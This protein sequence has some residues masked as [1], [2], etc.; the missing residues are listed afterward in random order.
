MQ[1]YAT[2]LRWCRNSYC[3]KVHCLSFSHTVRPKSQSV[4]DRTAMIVDMLESLTVISLNLSSRQRALW[5]KLIGLSE[6]FREHR[7]TRMWQNNSNR[8]SIVFFVQLVLPA[9]R[10]YSIINEMMV[11]SQICP[12]PVQCRLEQF[13][14]SIHHAVLP[15]GCRWQS[16]EHCYRFYLWSL[17]QSLYELRI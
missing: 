8:K 15:G 14:D 12:L 13:A 5:S 3:G 4:A 1:L 16:L 2:K 17:C 11:S 7:H 9:C 6:Q 10:L